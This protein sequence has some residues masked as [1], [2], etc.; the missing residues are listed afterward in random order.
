MGQNDPIK[1][2]RGANGDKRVSRP[3]F[4]LR[5]CLA[6]KKLEEQAWQLPPGRERDALLKR[7]RLL[8]AEDHIRDWLSSPSLQSPK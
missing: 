1:P 3:S 5:I 2:N 7:A 4:E 8:N 6:A